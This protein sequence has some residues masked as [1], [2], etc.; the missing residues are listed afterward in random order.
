MDVLTL[1]I[2]LAVAVI[3]QVLVLYWIIRLAVAG[4]IRDTTPSSH[5]EASG[6]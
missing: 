2:M 3:V 4:G 5:E 1:I 6:P